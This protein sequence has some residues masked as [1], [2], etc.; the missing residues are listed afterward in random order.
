MFVG[1]LLADNPRLPLAAVRAHRAG[2]L[3]SG[4]YLIDLD[5]LAANAALIADAAAAAGLA[6]YSWRSSTAATRTPATPQLAPACQ[7][8]WPSTCSAYAG[9]DRRLAC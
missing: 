6:L 2:A 1:R 4:T 5:A 7:P 3:I 8:R 9:S